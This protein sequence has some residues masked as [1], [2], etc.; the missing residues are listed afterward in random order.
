VHKW[1]FYKTKML[2]GGRM[3][4]K[5]VNSGGGG[6]RKGEG[7]GL[8]WLGYHVKIIR[9]EEKGPKSL[10]PMGGKMK[11]RGTNTCFVA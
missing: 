9:S 3:E 4:V 11:G 8:L 2:G 7:E 10:H 6:Q 5:I 1:G